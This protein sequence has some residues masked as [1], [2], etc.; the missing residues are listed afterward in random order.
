MGIDMHKEFRTLPNAVAP[1]K[2]TENNGFSVPV[3]LE[4]LTLGFY[5]CHNLIYGALYFHVVQLARSFF[6]G[7][8]RVHFPLYLK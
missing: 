1:L 8:G 7:Y 3:T 6:N 5:K 2:A 4:E